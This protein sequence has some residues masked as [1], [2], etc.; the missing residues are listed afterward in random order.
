VGNSEI[1]MFNDLWAVS[2]D[3]KIWV[4]LTDFA[5]TWT[6]MD[7]VAR[8]PFQCADKRHCAVGCQYETS[9]NEH[10]FKAYSCSAESAPPPAIGTMRPTVGNRV[11]EGGRVAVSWAER[12]GLDPTYTW[13]GPLQLALAQIV[14]VNDL[15]TLVGYRRNLTPT[16]AHPDGRDLWSNPGGRQ[17]VGAGYEPWDYSSDDNCLGVASDVFLSTAKPRVRREVGPSSQAFVD[18]GSWCRNPVLEFFDITA[19]DEYVYNYSPNGAWGQAQ[20]YGHWEEPVVFAADDKGRE[21]VAF[22]SSANLTPAWNPIRHQ[23]TFGLDT[24]LVRKDRSSPAA[25]IT[26]FNNES[27]RELAYPTTFDPKTSALY[28]SV[29]PGGMGGENP[30]GAI[31]I[32]D[33]P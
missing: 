4:Q 22:G 25:R 6:Q 30:P 8:L 15:P 17:V 33:L 20:Y 2:V 9:G 23:K 1:G 32:I 29:V 10:P 13:G 26:Y 5:A 27:K 11:H 7:S 14:L 3:G 24:W 12:V 21:F 28:L 31:Y 19:H 16:P 18:V